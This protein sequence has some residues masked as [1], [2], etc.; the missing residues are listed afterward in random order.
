MPEDD[1]EF[2]LEDFVDWVDECRCGVAARCTHSWCSKSDRV[3]WWMHCPYQNPQIN[4]LSNLG[5][6]SAKRNMCGTTQLCLRGIC[7]CTR[8][9][10][11]QWLRT[12]NTIN[13]ST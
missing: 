12:K 9:Y 5:V 4:L 13:R 3:R 1:D 6:K 10:E 7:I 11:G 8:K 2:D